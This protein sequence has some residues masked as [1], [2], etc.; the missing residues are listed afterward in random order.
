[1]FVVD[2][3]GKGTYHVF[4]VDE[5]LVKTRSLFQEILI[6][7]L[8]DFGKALFLDNSLQCAE[9]D[10]KIYHDALVQPALRVCEHP[11]HVLIIGGGDGAA[12]QTLLSSVDTK[13]TI[14]DIDKKV[15][16]LSKKY[17]REF[18]NNVFNNN[19]LKVIYMDGYEF[20]KKS[21]A[22]FDIVIVDA[23]D[24]GVSHV[25]NTIYSRP[26]FN[27]IRQRLSKDGLVVVQAGSAWFRKKEFYSVGKILSK[28]FSSVVPY[29]EFIHSFG[30]MWG[31]YIS[32]NKPQPHVYSVIRDL[33]YRPL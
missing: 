33:G 14:V 23:T 2:Q 10:Q 12:A 21:K 26:F 9:A 11:K 3:L 15:V 20:I 4:R 29:G 22:L 1:M 30:S 32:T 17:L 24:P 7:R 25:A 18:N 13:V 5:L 28:V 19:D 6:C 8:S 27:T 31:F 16:A